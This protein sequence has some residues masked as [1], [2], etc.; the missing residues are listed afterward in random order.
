[1]ARITVDDALENIANR[2]DLT[3]VTAM[4]ARQIASEA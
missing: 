4:R 1:M 2:F 3:L